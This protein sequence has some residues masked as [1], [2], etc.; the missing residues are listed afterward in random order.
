MSRGSKLGGMA[1]GAL[2][3]TLAVGGVRAPVAAADCSAPS[4]SGTEGVGSPLTA[5]A[6]GCS[7]PFAPNVTL[8]WYRC[9][10]STPATCTTSVKPAQSSPSSYTPVVADVGMRLGVKQVASSV[11][12]GEE[13]WR[14]TGPVPQPPGPPPPPPPPSGGG[15]GSATPLLSPF[16]VV[17]VAG[18]LTSRGARVTRLSVRAPAG[19]RVLG[20]CRGRTC[21]VHRLRTRV[22]PGR[23]VRLRRFQSR[24]RSKTVLVLLVTK[25]GFIGKYT[26][27]RIRRGKPPK[28]TDLCVQ[29]GETT[30]SACPA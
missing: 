30:G 10:G 27:F 17:I 14:L 24:L 8:Q 11:V 5:K 20:R 16:P 3:A 7:D 12:L 15:G 1:L 6:G 4:I 2:L 25:P 21:P 28:R 13:D 18:R 23:S 22:G 26:R 9:T 29:P 19:S